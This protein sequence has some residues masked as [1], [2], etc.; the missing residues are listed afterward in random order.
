MLFTEQTAVIACDALTSELLYGFKR[1]FEISGSDPIVPD[2][3]K[4]TDWSS[5]S[6]NLSSSGDEIL[7][8]GDF[9][10]L[11]DGVSWGSSTEILDPS[12]PNV[13]PDHSI[14]RYPP[15][16]DHDSAADRRDQSSPIPG[17]VDLSM[18][19]LTPSP[20]STFNP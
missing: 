15:G 5:G 3:V 19:T 9:G 17:Q 10:L 18:P 2:M 16:E 4:D 13:S 8:L 11:V 1:N 7:L 6:L 12:I 20:T 14:E